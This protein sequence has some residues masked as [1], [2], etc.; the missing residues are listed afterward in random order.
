MA[1][2]RLESWTK[3]SR[4]CVLLPELAHRPEHV[5]DESEIHVHLVDGSLSLLLPLKLDTSHE[6]HGAP[7]LRLAGMQQSIVMRLRNS[8]LVAGQHFAAFVI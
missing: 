5:L 7:E 1:P 8:E 4:D 3:Y 6:A 2:C